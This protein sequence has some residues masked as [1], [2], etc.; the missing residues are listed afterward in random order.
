[1]KYRILGNISGKQYDSL[2][3]IAI[4]HSNAF[5]L[6]TFKRV[7][8]KNLSD[9]YFELLNALS[10]YEIKDIYDW[11]LSPH[12]ESGQA[13]HIYLLNEITERLLAQRDGLYTWRIPDCPENLSFYRNKNAWLTSISHERFCFLNNAPA[14]AL[15]DLQKEGFDLLSIE[16]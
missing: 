16:G 11:S 12:Y 7:H 9:Y 2:L 15:R 14:E 8:R 3:R 6:S 4:K 13:I 10:A 1:M 5:G